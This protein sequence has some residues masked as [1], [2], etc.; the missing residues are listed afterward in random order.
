MVYL[1][2]YTLICTIAQRVKQ[3]KSQTGFLS[4][5]NSRQNSPN[6][7]VERDDPKLLFG[8]PSHFALR[9]RL[10]QTLA[11]MTQFAYFRGPKPEFAQYEFV[12]LSEDPIRSCWGEDISDEEAS[13]SWVIPG[14][15]I[16]AMVM[17][18]QNFKSFDDFFS[19]H[20]YELISGYIDSCESI[21]FAYCGE[22]DSV[23]TYKSKFNF[24][25]AVLDQAVNNG[26]MV[27]A[28]YERS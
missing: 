6:T 26:C 9:R 23:T 19:S 12:R 18:A 14:L 2:R 7:S 21:T 24:L 27:H 16:D 22:A 15:S 13:A 10:S 4:N 17:A 20:L 5:E 1:A 25:A 28:R 11:A 8:F 3:E